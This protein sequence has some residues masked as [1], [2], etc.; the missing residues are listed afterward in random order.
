MCIRDSFYPRGPDSVARRAG[1]QMV[2]LLKVC[3]IDLPIR[4]EKLRREIE[5][6]D[7]LLV[8]QPGDT[9]VHL[10]NLRHR[11]QVIP[12]REDAQQ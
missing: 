10:R 1:V 8:V 3:H 9:F 12:S 11:Q 6:K 2:R 5:I 7:V 4:P